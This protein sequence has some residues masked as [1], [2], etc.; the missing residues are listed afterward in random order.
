MDGTTT[1]RPLASLGDAIAAMKWQQ[2][3]GPSQGFVLWIGPQRI[4]LDLLANGW[5]EI[6]GEAG[7]GGREARLAQA[8]ATVGA[9]LELAESPSCMRC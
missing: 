9:R 8:I 1:A 5:L 3:D 4:Q 7:Q 6:D 2:V